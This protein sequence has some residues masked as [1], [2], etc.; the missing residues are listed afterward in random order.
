MGKN[1]QTIKFSSKINGT[2]PMILPPLATSQLPF[3]SRRSARWHQGG[4]RGP[5]GAAGVPPVGVAWPATIYVNQKP[6]MGP[7]LCPQKYI[8]GP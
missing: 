7:Y 6:N 5:V 4:G 2:C 8:G 3:G 1:K